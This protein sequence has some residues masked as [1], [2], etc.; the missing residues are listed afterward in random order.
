MIFLLFKVT[1]TKINIYLIQKLHYSIY[2]GYYETEKKICKAAYKNI[3]LNATRETC[4]FIIDIPQVLPSTINFVNP[5]IN[6][7]YVFKV[8]AYFRWHLPVYMDL[9][10]VIGTT[11]V[12]HLEF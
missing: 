8:I 4:N 9:P 12:H 1:I 11:P 3:S 5:M 10:V 6:I 2:S 7:S